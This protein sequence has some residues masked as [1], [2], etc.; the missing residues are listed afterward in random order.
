LNGALGVSYNDA[1]L[2]DVHVAPVVQ[3]LFS[4][5]ERDGDINGDPVNTG[6]TRLIA[7]PGIEF[8]R[9]AWKFYADVEVPF[10][11]DMNGHQLVAPAALKFILSRSF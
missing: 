11:Q 10:Y 7:A 1:S 6:Y 5:R 3:L 8:D 9:E 4:R 2:G